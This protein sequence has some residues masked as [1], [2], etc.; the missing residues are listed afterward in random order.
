MDN[1]CRYFI[2]I[3]DL[4]SIRVLIDRLKI[5]IESLLKK[6]EFDIDDVVKVVIEEIRKK[7]DVFMKNVEDLGIQTISWTTCF[8]TLEQ[9]IYV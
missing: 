7:F 6:V 4:D 2:T 3:K 5:E 9:F 1:A 8:S